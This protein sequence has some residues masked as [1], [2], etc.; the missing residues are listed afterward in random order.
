MNTLRHKTIGIGVLLVTSLN[1]FLFQ[2]RDKNTQRNP[3]KIAPFGGG[4][5]VGE[6]VFDCAIRELQEELGAHVSKQDLMEIGDFESHFTPGTYIKMFVVKNVNPSN[7]NLREGKSIREMT[8]G[9]ALQHSEVT[10][11]TKEVLIK[12]KSQIY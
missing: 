8:M 1:T 6:D 10:G 2:E 11:F 9:E 5:D 4:L 3:G 12:Y 7:L